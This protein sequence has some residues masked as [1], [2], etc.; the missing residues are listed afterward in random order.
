[1]ERFRRLGASIPRELSRF[2]ERHGTTIY[3]CGVV[4][5]F[6]IIYLTPFV[7]KIVGAGQ[8]G[9]MFRRFRDGV[10]PNRVYLEGLQIVPPWDNFT[11]YD[12]RL[13]QVSEEFDVISKNGLSIKVSLSIRF[14]PKLEFLPRLH[15]EVGPDYVEKIVKPEV[16]AMIRAVFGQYI[17]EEIY[18]TQNALI[19]TSLRNA[20]AAMADRYVILDD[21]LL[22]SITLPDSLRRA[23]ESKVT[24]EQRAL[25]MRFVNL[26]EE[27]EAERKIIE[28]RGISVAQ[29]IVAETLT[30]DL[31][32]FKGIEATLDLATS[33]N[34][35][36]IVIG[37]RDGLPV[38][39]DTSDRG[40]S[41][42]RTNANNTGFGSR[43]NAAGRPAASTSGT[44]QFGAAE[45]RRRDRKPE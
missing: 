16:R 28:A 39:L 18:T 27:K 35:K 38:I 13:Q 5:L 6:L 11:M 17:P 42:S 2:W 12:L 1:M 20:Q 25:E 22:K 10:E 30:E 9:V 37:G 45:D 32:R 24:Q 19:E 15:K 36:V 14:R 21:L 3:I 31:L 33:E 44:N 7:F 8:A 29:K 4:A 34:A 41:P 43:L 40:T 26:R 23:I